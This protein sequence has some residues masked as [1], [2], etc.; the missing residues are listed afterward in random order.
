M[1][2]QPLNP[3][4]R[5]GRKLKRYR[6]AWG[7]TALELSQAIKVDSKIYKRI[8]IGLG[9]LD[10]DT[11]N[12]LAELYNVTKEVFQKDG[13]PVELRKDI[14]DKVIVI[15]RQWIVLRDGTIKELLKEKQQL[16][17]EIKKLKKEIEELRDE[18]N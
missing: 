18:E 4:S 14:R 6:E 5:T 1:A 16:I 10:E 3:K 13:S 8:E 17:N 7:L 12:K 15:L 2:K 11:F 9:S